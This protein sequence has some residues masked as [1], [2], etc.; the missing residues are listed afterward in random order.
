[1]PHGDG[2][3]RTEDRGRKPRDG[4][5]PTCDLRPPSSARRVWLFRLTAILLGP[6]L[7]LGLLELGLRAFG[8][9]YNPHVAIPCEIDGKRFLGENVKFGWRFFPPILARE[10]EPFLFAAEKPADTCRIFVLGS[11]AAQGAPNNAFRFGRI[12]EAMLQERFPDLRF[13]VDHGRHGRDQ[14]ARDSGNRPRLCAVRSG[15]LRRVPG[16]QRGASDPTA[17]AR[18]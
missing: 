15:F 5:P 4:Q 17:P 12:L 11:S 6:I 3:R 18:S 10:F 7:F 1:M 8:Y 13:E 14:L 16:Q 2:R 9:G